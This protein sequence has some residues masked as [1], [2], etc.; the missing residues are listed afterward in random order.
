M[1]EYT[2]LA[3][4][5]LH[6]LKGNPRRRTSATSR[7]VDKEVPD[8]KIGT[9]RFAGRKILA[10]T[11]FLIATLIAC[12]RTKSEPL[13]EFSIDDLVVSVQ[14]AAQITNFHGFSSDTKKSDSL[15]VFDPNTPEVCRAVYDENFA[16]GTG[17]TAFRAVTYGGSA[18]ERIKK[19]VSLS[20]SVATYPDADVSHAAFDRLESELTKCSSAHLKGYELTVQRPDSSTLL[21]NSPIWE[22]AYR[23]KSSVLMN[24]SGGGLP[25]TV[26]GIVDRISARLP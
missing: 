10:L 22:A 19:P 11:A 7:Q 26:I 17:L 18:G 24:V 21:L 2:Q 4:D 16:F 23:V 15:T 12:S 20:Q 8:L 3:V 14:D 9:P 13:Q 25:D 6:T 1:P 5:D